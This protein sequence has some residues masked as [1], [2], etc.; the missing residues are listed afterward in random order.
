MG[1]TECLIAFG[2]CLVSPAAVPGWGRKVLLGELL[3][4][5]EGAGAAGAET[6]QRPCD[7]GGHLQPLPGMCVLPSTAALTQRA[8]L[9]TGGLRWRLLVPKADA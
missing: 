7:A 2:L 5:G 4:E 8:S 9:C 1:C 6:L 3:R